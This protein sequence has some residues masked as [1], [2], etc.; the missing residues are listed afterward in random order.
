MSN[1]IRVGVELCRFRLR[2]EDGRLACVMN[3]PGTRKDLSEFWLYS[4]W[5]VHGGE[6][7]VGDKI[8]FAINCFL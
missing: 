4:R 3:L 8:S 5:K 7:G 1:D 2:C 6:I